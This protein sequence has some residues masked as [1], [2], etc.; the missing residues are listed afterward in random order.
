MRRLSHTL[1]D[2]KQRDSRLSPSRSY[3][4]LLSLLHSVWVTLL[5]L[6]LFLAPFPLSFSLP[7]CSSLFFFLF[8]FLS[9]FLCLSV[10]LSLFLSFFL[11]LSACLSVCRSS[12]FVVA[13]RGE[14]CVLFV[15]CVLPHE[16]CALSTLLVCVPCVFCSIH[17][18]FIASSF[19][20]VA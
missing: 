13:G 8:L 9:F 7:T 16:S 3:F 12:P 10:C 17:R 20:Q 2:S 18:V 15:A 14:L 19:L 1:F 11:C 5:P 6:C 4:V